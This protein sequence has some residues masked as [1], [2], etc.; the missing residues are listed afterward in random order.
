MIQRIQTI[1]M[2]IAAIL[3]FLTMKLPFYSGTSVA[4]NTY[5]ELIATDNFFILILTS[6]LGTG[7]FIDIFLY[8]HRSIQ[9]RILI[10]AILVECIIIFLYIN[11]TK[12]YSSGNFS[13]WSVLH[14][15]IIVFIT[16]AAKG[17]YNDSK[18]I[19]ESNRLR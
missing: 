14:L 5:H 9:F 16:M 17:I 13:V 10:F 2:I 4:D 3:V 15:L 18:L 8:K 19:K 6:A 12:H 11:A 7:I 1:W